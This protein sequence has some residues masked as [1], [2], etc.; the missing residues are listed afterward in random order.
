[1]P[2]TQTDPG[3]QAQS[4][5]TGEDKRS[6]VDLISHHILNQFGLTEITFY[7]HSFAVASNERSERSPSLLRSAQDPEAKMEAD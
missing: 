5:P 4:L 1:M 2:L 6:K 7:E 3:L